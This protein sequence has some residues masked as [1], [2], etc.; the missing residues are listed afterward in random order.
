MAATLYYFPLGG[1][2]ELIRLIAAAGGVDL[3]EGGMG[4]D[5]DKSEFGSPSSLPILQHGDL[6]MSQSG[7][8]EQYMSLLA[9]PDLTPPQRA[10]D[11]QFG[12]IKED[13]SAAQSGLYL[14]PKRAQANVENAKIIAKWFP[15]V[16]GLLPADGFINGKSYPTTADLVVFNLINNF[17]PCAVAIKHSGVNMEKEYPKMTALAVRSG[18]FPKVQAYVARS[19]TLGAD[20][21]DAASMSFAPAIAEAL[22]L[23]DEH[24]GQADVGIIG[25]ATMGANLC[26]N[27][28]D[29]GF[30]LAVY[31][32]T[33]LT[34]EKFVTENR[35]K[36]GAD[37]VFGAAN[38]ADF[39][40]LLKKTP[41]GTHPCRRRSSHGWRHRRIEQSF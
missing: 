38:F 21:A 8:I 9:F 40:K 31:N 23:K 10:K 16:E 26:L 18:Q 12:C 25:L 17:Y 27:I 32:R 2:G 39:A 41:Q 5:V 28:L 15:V 30:K 7:A 14:G 35:A 36:Y 20:Y 37:K 34:S 4:A 13:I 3:V 29:K 24:V 19:F 6:K 1:R 11:C 22:Q 33:A